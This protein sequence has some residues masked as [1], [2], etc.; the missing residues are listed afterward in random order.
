MYNILTFKLS[1]SHISFLLTASSLSK[2]YC[3][4]FFHN[5]WGRGSC[6]S[7]WS[8]AITLKWRNFTSVPIKVHLLRGIIFCKNWTE[9]INRWYRCF[10]Y[11]NITFEKESGRGYGKGQAGDRGNDWHLCVI[12]IMF[13]YTAHWFLLY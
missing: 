8:H 2:I 7:A 1:T 12:L 11:M 13:W 5:P 3:P 6:D 4:K 9:T 10:L